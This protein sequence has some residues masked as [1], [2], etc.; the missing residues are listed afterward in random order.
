M[1]GYPLG[2]S[3]VPMKLS[4]GPKPQSSGRSAQALPL[5]CV[6]P[7][8]VTLAPGRVA[9][10]GVQG[11]VA[12]EAKDQDAGGQTRHQKRQEQ[13]RRCSTQPPTPHFSHGSNS[14]YPHGRPGP[15]RR[16]CGRC[17]NLTQSPGLKTSGCAGLR[18]RQAGEQRVQLLWPQAG[19]ALVRS[20]HADRH[21]RLW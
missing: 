12:R 17:A 13:H 8:N 5:A 3:Q 18:G 1:A 14:S 4:I 21:T 2:G 16:R 15:D 20:V 9:R 10:R 19:T 6:R 11:R 7:Q